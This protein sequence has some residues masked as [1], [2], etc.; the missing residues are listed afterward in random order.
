MLLLRPAPCLQGL[1]AISTNS[2]GGTSQVL[3][4]R[5]CQNHVWG[6]G[7]CTQGATASPV[8][9]ASIS[10]PE[11]RPVFSPSLTVDLGVPI[12]TDPLGVHLLSKLTLAVVI[13]LGW[14][15]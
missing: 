5:T 10:K 13:G 7:A 4:K 3:H 2:R 1:T 11:G 12:S 15:P 14:G 9:E 6:I 8:V